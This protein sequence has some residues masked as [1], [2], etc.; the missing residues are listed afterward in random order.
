MY[1]K[2]SKKTAE[3][4]YCHRSRALIVTFEQNQHINQ[5]FPLL[6]LSIFYV[7]GFSVKKSETI[8][9]KTSV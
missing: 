1:T 4:Y 6:A 2:L 7:L 3:Q 8:M 5:M 9:Q